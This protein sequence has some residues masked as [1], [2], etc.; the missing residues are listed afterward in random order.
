LVNKYL[1]KNEMLR[2]VY[3][4]ALKTE[5][6]EIKQAVREAATICP[7]PCK[8]TISL[9]LFARWRGCSGMLAI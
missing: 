8:L 9:H 2:V 5:R 4:T 1:H 7:R 6:F 3:L